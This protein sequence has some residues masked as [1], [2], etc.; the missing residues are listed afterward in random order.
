MRP[1]TNKLETQGITSKDNDNNQ[2]IQTQD[3]KLLSPRAGY[4]QH[5]SPFRLYTV[6]H[7]CS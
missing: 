1:E 6:L 3:N 5:T 7:A 2:Q 4:V